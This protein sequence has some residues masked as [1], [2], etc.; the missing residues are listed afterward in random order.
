MHLLQVYKMASLINKVA[1]FAPSELS[2]DQNKISSL[3]KEITQ[4]D[5]FAFKRQF[6]LG[7]Q[8][9]FMKR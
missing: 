8:L 1:P 5:S 7:D 9:S 4:K 3:E 2:I 6:I